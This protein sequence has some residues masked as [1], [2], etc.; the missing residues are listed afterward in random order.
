MTKAPFSA[1]VRAFLTIAPRLRRASDMYD[2]KMVRGKMLTRNGNSHCDIVQIGELV[3]RFKVENLHAEGV[4][5][6]VS[7]NY[8]S[9][10]VQNAL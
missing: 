8:M 4:C 5:K 1:H 10:T 3:L 9:V 6:T 2:I 7:E